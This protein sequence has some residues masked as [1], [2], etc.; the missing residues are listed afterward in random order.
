MVFYHETF[1]LIFV[2][3]KWF[4]FILS[5]GAWAEL[6]ILLA[7]CSL[8]VLFPREVFTGTESMFLFAVRY[9]CSIHL[10]NF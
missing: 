10:C 9:V 6:V 1:S 4:E 3:H 5:F 7:G 2:F 8:L